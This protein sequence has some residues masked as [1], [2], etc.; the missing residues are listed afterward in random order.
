MFAGITTLVSVVQFA[1]P[2]FPTFVTTHV[3]K[4]VG[5]VKTEFVVTVLTII[6][7]LFITL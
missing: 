1:I 5:K 3:P 4:A 7:S 6:A 2:I